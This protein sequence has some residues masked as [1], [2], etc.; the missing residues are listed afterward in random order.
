MKGLF[1]KDYNVASL[2]FEIDRII[3]TRLNYRKIYPLQTDIQADLNYKKSLAFNKDK[4]IN[5]MSF[6]FW[7]NLLVLKVHLLQI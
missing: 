7:D 1:G 2:L 6:T 5:M 4:S 3:L